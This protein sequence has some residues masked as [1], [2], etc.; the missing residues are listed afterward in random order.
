VTS[1]ESAAIRKPIRILVVDDYEP[2]RRFVLLTLQMCPE[3]E[4]IGEVS[5]GL[6]AV[7]KAQELQPD[8]IVLDIGVP[9][10][11]GIEAA[12][13]IRAHTPQS[14]ILFLSEN[15]SL[16]VAE[17]ALRSGGNGYVLK[18]EAAGELTPAVKAVLQ[19]KRFVSASLAGRC[20][21]DRPDPSTGYRP[22]TNNVIVPSPR[23][24]EVG[25]YSDDRRLLEHLTQFVGAALKGGN[26]AIVAATESHRAAL[27]PRLQVYGLDMG[28]A[29]EDG[30][31][32]ALDAVDALASFLRSRMPDPVLFVKVFDQV[33][34]TAAKAAKGNHSRVAIYG[35]CVQLLWMQGNAE[36]A[37]QTERLANQLIKA[38]DVNILC[39]YLPSSVPGGMDGDTF[40]GICAEHSAVRSI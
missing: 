37:I 21:S 4:V 6:E 7:Q 22:F 25:F 29:I 23:S 15:R 19:G 28:A 12:R 36:A 32:V 20:S 34:R 31:Y 9:T 5:D 40:Q 17:E 10:L 1:D 11:N 3:Y 14:R 38:Y 16:E 27:L 8:L 18:S 24:H 39:G 26:A 2:W 30:R 13:R 35:E 33:I